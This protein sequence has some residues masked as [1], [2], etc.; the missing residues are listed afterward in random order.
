M[1]SYCPILVHM[2]HDPLLTA[3]QAAVILGC[4][5][6]TVNRC[7]ADGRL[8]EAQRLPGY[9]GARLFRRKDVE[10]LAARQAKNR[11]ARSAA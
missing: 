7:A 2:P 8:K 6:W 1:R 11:A 9:G 5:R 4:S 10:R 3:T